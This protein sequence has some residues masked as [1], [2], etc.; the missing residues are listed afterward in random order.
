MGPSPAG[1]QWSPTVSPSQAIRYGTEG[2][3]STRGLGTHLFSSAMGRSAAQRPLSLVQRA[4]HVMLGATMMYALLMVLG[5][6]RVEP[7][8]TRPFNGNR[9]TPVTMTELSASSKVLGMLSAQFFDLGEER[10]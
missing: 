1:R 4:V 10:L 2:D 7:G 5:M 3:A 6:W 8:H 9:G